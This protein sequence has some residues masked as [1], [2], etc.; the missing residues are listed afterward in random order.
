MTAG[1]QV[2]WVAG[3]SHRWWSAGFLAILWGSTVIGLTVNFVL[4]YGPMSWIG[5]AF[6]LGVTGAI[7]F[8][9]IFAYSFLVPTTARLGIMSDGIIVEAASVRL[10]NYGFRQGCRWGDLRLLGNR[11]VLPRIHPRAPRSVRL[12]AHQ[13]TLIA[14]RVPPG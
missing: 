10:R 6:Y 3:F 2:D 4:G 14:P 11:L 12:T 9:G 5:L 1:A 7:A 13:L 8:P